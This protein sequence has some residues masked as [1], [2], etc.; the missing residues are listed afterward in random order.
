M[1]AYRMI[2]DPPVGC[3]PASTA[4]VGAVVPAA[5]APRPIYR[6]DRVLNSQDI[7]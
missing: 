6:R 5:I 4:A 2:L 1:L 3:L 7:F